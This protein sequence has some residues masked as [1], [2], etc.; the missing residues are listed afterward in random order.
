[1]KH[2]LALVLMVFGIVGC[3]SGTL[4]I[5]PIDEYKDDINA[6]ELHFACLAKT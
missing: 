6:V 5:F 3:A 2:T 1:M 4:A